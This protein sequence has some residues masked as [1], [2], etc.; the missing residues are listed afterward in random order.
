MLYS[1]W[2]T[3]IQFTSDFLTVHCHRFSGLLNNSIN[4]FALKS[5]STNILHRDFFK[6]T[7]V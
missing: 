4:I 1:F 7:L 6:R 2:T 5:Y 3:A